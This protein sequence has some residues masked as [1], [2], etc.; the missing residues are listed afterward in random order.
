M[1]FT[2]TV[3]I[4]GIQF[5]LLRKSLLQFNKCDS[6]FAVLCVSCIYSV[7]IQYLLSCFE[8]SCKYISLYI[9]HSVL[10]ISEPIACIMKSIWFVQCKDLIE[11]TH[12]TQSDISFL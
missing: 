12:E 2:I 8:V 11:F 9:D 10:Q 7:P 3:V 6:E 4:R 1:W 5:C